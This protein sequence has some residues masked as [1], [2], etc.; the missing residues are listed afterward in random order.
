MKKKYVYFFPP[1]IG[2]VIFGVVYWQYSSGHE[3]RL[4]ASEAKV[5]ADIQ[6]KLDSDA[7]SRE[8]AVKDAL[9]A[10]ER[11]KQE[12]AAKEIKDAADKEMREKAMQ[13]K[14]RA[15]REA[16]KLE[17]QVKRLKKEIDEE[18]KE[19]KKINAEKTRS[20][21]EITFQREYVKK[22]EENV[23]SLETVLNRIKAADEAA[24]AAARAAKAAAAAA[25]KK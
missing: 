24:E 5:R 25:A 6:A 13:A 16:D 14:F 19:I 9:A 22:A 11:R 15:Q 18:E 2:L 12:K 3:A 17:Q 20:T 1:L 7:R 8:K 10:Q 4:A 23:R 21:D